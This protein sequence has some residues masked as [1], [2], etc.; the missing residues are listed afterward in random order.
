MN[1]EKGNVSAPPR[2]L[3]ELEQTPFL[4]NEVRAVKGQ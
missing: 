1:P 4:E 3:A 2:V